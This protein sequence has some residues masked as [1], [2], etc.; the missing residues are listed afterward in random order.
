MNPICCQNDSQFQEL[1]VLPIWPKMASQSPFLNPVEVPAVVC[2]EDG[3][4]TV[5]FILITFPHFMN[6]LVLRS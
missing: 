5:V 2:P 3:I 1:Y 4:T 6:K